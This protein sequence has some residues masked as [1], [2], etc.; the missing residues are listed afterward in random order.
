MIVE[1]KRGV[2]KTASVWM[3]SFLFSVILY[4]LVFS[5]GVV[6]K[7]DEVAMA[8]AGNALGV[9]VSVAPVPLPCYACKQDSLNTCSGRNNK[10]GYSTACCNKACYNVCDAD[11]DN[12]CNACAYDTFYNAV[13][14]HCLHKALLPSAEVSQVS[15]FSFSY[16]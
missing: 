8:D 5:A 3:L 4:L 14:G 11:D 12:V 9:V 10:D 1:T 2:K 6:V 16:L 15:L 7:A 13:P